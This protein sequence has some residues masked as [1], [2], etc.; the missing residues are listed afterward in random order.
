MATEYIDRTKAVALINQLE[1]WTT[2]G[3]VVVERSEVLRVL[4]EMGHHRHRV[5]RDTTLA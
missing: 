3:A 2:A 4:N 1:S 5:P